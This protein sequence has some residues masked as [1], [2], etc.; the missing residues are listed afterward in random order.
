MSRK[1]VVAANA[2]KPQ[3]DVLANVT[4]PSRG[5]DRLDGLDL[6]HS[7]WNAGLNV[8]PGLDRK[9]ERNS[10]R[11]SLIAYERAKREKDLAEDQ[12]KL[13][14]RDAWRSLDQAKRSYEI[15]IE[16]VKLNERR[17]EE[18]DL[19]A[20][21]GKATALNRV[22]AQNDLTQAENN[23]TAALV[24]HTIARLEFW[25]DMGILFIKEDGQWEEITDVQQSP[26]AEA[27]PGPAS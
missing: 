7:Q 10:Y 5:K 14:V 4:I 8:D 22:D 13:E 21:L 3:L 19:L 9:A 26:N 16:G 1:V 17:V 24:G 18:Q 23:R 12:V 27:A 20:E 15:A 2:L 25:R 11:A 6:D